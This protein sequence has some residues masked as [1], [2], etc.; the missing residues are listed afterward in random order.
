MSVDALRQ[1][2]PAGRRALAKAITLLES[3]L[4]AHRA[5]ADALLTACL[6]HSGGAVRLGLSGVPG[7]GKSSFIEALGLHLIQQGHRVAVLAVDPSSSLSGGSILGDKTRMERLS[8]QEAAFIRP[9]PSRGVLGGVASHTRELIRI[10]EAAGYDVVIVE[11]VGVGQSEVAVAGMTDCFCLLQL[12][13]AGD[14]LQAIKRGVMELAD[15]VVIHKADLDAAAAMRAQV[16]IVSS[17]RLHGQAHGASAPVEVLQASSLTGQGVAEVWQAVQRQQAAQDRDARRH[18]QDI[19]WLHE[20]IQA[21][22]QQAFHDHAAVAARL[23]GLEQAVRA[24]TLAASTAARDLLTL[25]L[26]NTPHG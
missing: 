24:G 12:P 26:R 16:H 13:N 6:P 10:V 9:S 18:R 14:E 17:L 19:A 22:L 25:F 3:S 8:V 15:L 23:P 4:P 11:T 21:G 5:Q 2:G 1:G 7:V 20:R